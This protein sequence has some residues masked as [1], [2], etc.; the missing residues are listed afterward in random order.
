MLISLLKG[1]MSL[2]FLISGWSK[3][4]DYKTLQSSLERSQIPT[5]VAHS[6]AFSLP[7]V[8]LMLGLGYLNFGR[9]L[10]WSIRITN[11]LL[12][13]F[14]AY[15][16]RDI[17]QGRKGS[18]ACFGQHLNGIQ[19]WWA[20][21]RNGILLFLSSS[22]AKPDLL[23][24]IIT[25]VRS[26]GRRLGAVGSISMLIL[27]GVGIEGWRRTLTSA[28]SL[29]SSASQARIGY[30]IGSS[31]VVD[32]QGSRSKI[33]DLIERDG[34]SSLKLIF[35]R[36]GCAP[37]LNLMSHVAETEKSVGLYFILPIESMPEIVAEPIS[38]KNLADVLFDDTGTLFQDAGIQATP[39]AIE[40]SKA[41]G[42]IVYSVS[43]D[44]SIEGWLGIS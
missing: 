14:S 39:T 25:L 10:A 28:N 38:Y 26:F 11:S 37:C 4:K 6:V 24:C 27:L 13:V 1:F 31:S 32:V 3:I 43:G 12:L 2:V 19:G 35:V 5:A 18:C 29:P 7:W 33:Q 22:I 40:V 21:C 23:T 44:A 8:E 34:V 20:I 17:I 16:F 42:E 9:V 41:K 36:M 30:S 15:L